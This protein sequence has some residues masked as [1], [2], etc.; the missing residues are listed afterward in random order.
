[1]VTSLSN[2]MKAAE[3][4]VP[5]VLSVIILYKWIKRSLCE[6]K[7]CGHFELILI[8]IYVATQ[9]MIAQNA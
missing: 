3:Q 1:M 8:Y 2:Q 5:V 7:N 4:C 9:R 6:S